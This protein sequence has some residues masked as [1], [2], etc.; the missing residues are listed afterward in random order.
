MAKLPAPEMDV[1]ILDE[2]GKDISGA[3]MDTKVVNRSVQCEYNPW[4]NTP[5]SHRIFLRAL[6]G[7]TYHNGVGLGMADVVHDRL[8]GRYRLASHVYQFADSIDACRHPNTDSLFKR[9]RVPGQDFE[10]GREGRPGDRHLLP[11]QK[12]PGADARVCER[13]PGSGSLIRKHTLFPIHLLFRST[14][15]GILRTGR[16]RR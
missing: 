12:L 8:A 2:I 15:I 14:G 11:H 16:R 7:N 4:P 13:E 1:L 6:S 9:R 10:N 3:G 5:K